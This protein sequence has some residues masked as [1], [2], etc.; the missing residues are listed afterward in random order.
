MKAL[1]PE[2]AAWLLLLPLAVLAAEIDHVTIEKDGPRYRL[3]GEVMVEAP[4]DAVYRVITDYD[5]LERL[6]KGILESRLVERLDDNSALVYTRLAGCVVFFCRKIDRIERVEET[7][8]VGIVAVVVPADD[9][10]VRY[11]RSSWELGEADGG[12]R[13]VYRTEIEPGFWI[14]AVIGPPLVR[15]VLRRRVAATLVN[16]EQAAVEDQQ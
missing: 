2:R 16:L 12:T 5:A 11:E 3:E 15:N 8:P 6:D 14:P 7:P 9:G 4:I 1:R 10:D 13:I